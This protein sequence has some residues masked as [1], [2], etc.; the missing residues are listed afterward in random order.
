MLP[1]APDAFG[2]N[3]LREISADRWAASGVQLP[4]QPE[5]RHNRGIHYKDDML[6]RGVL[7]RHL[8]GCEMLPEWLLPLTLTAQEYGR[9]QRSKSG[10][11]TKRARNRLRETMDRAPQPRLADRLPAAPN[12]RC[13]SEMLVLN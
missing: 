13:R 4:V 9:S 12:Q 5:R 10:H 2:C 7:R 8:D 1:S 6:A 11:E 3:P